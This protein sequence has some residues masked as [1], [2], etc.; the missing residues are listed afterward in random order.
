MNWLKICLKY[1]RYESFHG[2]LGARKIVC[3]SEFPGILKNWWSKRK[4]KG[5]EEA[6]KKKKKTKEILNF[7]LL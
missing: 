6:N 4:S 7:R 3:W 5:K 2:C 1:Q